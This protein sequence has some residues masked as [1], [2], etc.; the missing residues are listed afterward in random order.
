[1]KFINNNC[2]IFCSFCS[3]SNR[4]TTPYNMQAL[5]PR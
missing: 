3:S 2:A 4:E 1:L 5:I